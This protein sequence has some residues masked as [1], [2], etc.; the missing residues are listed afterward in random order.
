MESEKRI[1]RQH[2]PA[3]KY[4]GVPVYKVPSSYLRWFLNHTN[5]EGRWPWLADAIRSHLRQ[6]E[7]K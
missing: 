7:G 1:E 4:R 5:I 2:M 3:G 6:E